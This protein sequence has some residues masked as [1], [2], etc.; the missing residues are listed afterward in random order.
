MSFYTPVFSISR[1]VKMKPLQWPVM[2]PLTSLTPS[3]ITASLSFF[4]S[5]YR[6]PAV[7]EDSC[8]G[9]ALGSLHLL[10]PLLRM[11]FLHDFLL[12]PPSG[13]HSDTTFSGTFFN[14]PTY[15]GFLPF[16]IS[17]LCLRFIRSTYQH[18]T[19]Y[20]LLICHIY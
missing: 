1:T 12:L 16:L 7:L 3:P 13:L 6:P 5:P 17:F 10:I 14:H 2:L 8:H 18:L 20:I 19:L 4:A 15:N 11:F 9:P